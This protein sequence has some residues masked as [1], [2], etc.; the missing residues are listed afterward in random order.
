MFYDGVGGRVNYRMWRVDG[1]IRAVLVFLH[2]RGQSSADYHRFGRAMGL[3]GIEVWALDHLGHGLSEGEP[4]SSPPLPDLA[5]NAEILIGLA[6][7]SR[8]GVPLVLA[9][10]SLGAAVALLMMRTSGQ[11]DGPVCAVALTGTPSR[12]SLLRAPAPPVPTLLLHGE[13]DRLTP[14]DPVRE[15]AS[16]NP[17]VELRVFEDAGHDLLHEPVRREVEKTM[18]EFTFRY[19]GSN[20]ARI[21][22]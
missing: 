18:A 16:R 4:D 14:I 13:D 1:G 2:G 21:I 10:H 15:W 22:S 6:H 20:S 9:G 12:D 3:H 5:A 17:G 19:G 11:G 7:A 8:P